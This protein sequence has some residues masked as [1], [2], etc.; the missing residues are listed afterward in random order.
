MSIK[1]AYLNSV[2]I[3]LQVSCWSY[4]IIEQLFQTGCGSYRRYQYDIYK[5][6][7][8]KFDSVRLKT[9]KVLRRLHVKA[10]F[11]RAAMMS[12]GVG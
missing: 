5:H 9:I 6:L 12:T 7:V 1:Y 2:T 11:T 3:H 10:G 4:L 8:C